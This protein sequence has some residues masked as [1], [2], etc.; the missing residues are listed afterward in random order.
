[1]KNLRTIGL[2]SVFIVIVFFSLATTTAAEAQQVSYGGEVCFQ[3]VSAAGLGAPPKFLQMGALSFGQ[4]HFPLHGRA[5]IQSQSDLA[6]MPVHGTALVDGNNVIVSLNVVGG[7][8]SLASSAAFRLALDAASLSG[9]YRAIEQQEVLTF[10]P[11]SNVVSSVDSGNAARI[12]CP[13]IFQTTLVLKDPS[14]AVKSE[15]PQGEMITLELTV[16]NLTDEPQG[17]S[18]PTSQLYEFLVGANQNVSPLWR[19]S[20]GKAFLQAVT[21]LLLSPRETKTFKEVWNQRD[22]GGSQV[23]PGTYR[24]QGFLAASWELN[25]PPLSP[26]VTGTR[27]P[28]VI[29]TIR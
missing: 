4:N 19:W 16:T 8:S 26:P 27:S 24:A 25:S 7:Q 6:T 1:M 29:F 12:P 13:Q 18:L 14:G 5:V 20:H 15:F 17:L 21:P 10:A 23:S 22:D 3:L 9:T 28:V 2:L 11:G